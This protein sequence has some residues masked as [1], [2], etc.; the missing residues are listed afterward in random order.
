MEIK[1]KQL[2]TIIGVSKM[3]K[4]YLLMMIPFLASCGG[5]D[6]DNDESNG[7]LIGRMVDAGVQNLT[8]I[9]DTQSGTTGSNGSFSYKP[10]ETVLFS[11]GDA[12]LP[13]VKAA[14]LV[15]PLELGR[16][17]D[18]IDPTVTNILIFLQSL[19]VD[20]NPNNGIVVSEEARQASALIDFDQPTAD[21]RSDPNVVNMLNNAGQ[22]TPGIVATIDAISHFQATLAS[23]GELYKRTTVDLEYVLTETGVSPCVAATVPAS[24][25][26]TVV[27][28]ED[29]GGDKSYACLGDG[30]SDCIAWDLDDK[31]IYFSYGDYDVYELTL[32]GS[33]YL[34]GRWIIEIPEAIG[35]GTTD[36]GDVTST[37]SLL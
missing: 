11:I 30:V 8:Y 23:L 34:S 13:S 14:P 31:G 36:C 17:T 35:G 21:F 12:Q 2:L 19:D 26:F 37:T 6:S 16:A 20:N 22:Q 29:S 10:G 27:T 15:T 9:T 3:K 5:G 18:V 32:D 33:G 4:A 24:H 1:D 7:V 28:T 25:Q